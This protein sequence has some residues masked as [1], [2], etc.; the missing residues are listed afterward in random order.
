MTITDARSKRLSR[1]E[2]IGLLGVGAG[3]GFG[4]ILGE[5][6]GLAQAQAGWLTA[7]ST[8]P[9]FPKGAIIRTVLKD[10]PPG[11]LGSGAT[12]F[13]EHLIG[14]YVSP[15]APSVTYGSPP[16][17]PAPGAKPAPPVETSIELMVEELRQSAKDGVRCIVDASTTKGSARAEK[18]VDFLKQLATRVPDVHVIMAGGPFI[19]PYAA[20]VIAKSAEQLTDEFVKL[21]TAQR[22]GAFGEIGSSME[23]TADARK[24]LTALAKAQVRTGLPLFSHTDHQ[25]C[26]KCALEQMHLFESNGVNVKNLVIGHLSDIKPGSEPLGQT[27]KAIAKRGAFLGF[28][29]VGHEMR[30]SRNPEAGKVALIVEMLNAGYEDNVLLSADFS[31]APQLKANWGNGFST[32]VLQFLPKLRYAGVKDAMLHKIMV[33]NPRRFLSFVPKPA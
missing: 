10:V 1:R 21:Q 23:M 7:Q 15:S 14:S 31:Y 33:D 5:D 20:D 6:L 18:D 12:M 30:A 19:A 4:T 9:T 8:P 27:A 3:L 17:S 28:D 32:V 25:G 16:P 2:A 22:W 13:H 11:A 24:V 26:A 29:T